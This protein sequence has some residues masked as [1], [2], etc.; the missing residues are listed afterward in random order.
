MAGRFAWPAALCASMLASC[1]GGDLYRP[2]SVEIEGLS[3]RA[4]ELVLMVFPQETGQTCV[5]VD[6][7]ASAGLMAPH[8]ARWVRS[9]MTER[10]FSL[11][12]IETE[13]ITVVA[14]SV[15]DAGAPIQFGCR[16]LSFDK[17]LDLELGVLYLAL[18]RRVDA[19]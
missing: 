11:P 6:L 10:A 4:S 13:G 18:S 14:Y 9:D 17:V 15:D 12:R 8:E 2:L 1:G 19:M 16:E 7:A 5:G 3:A